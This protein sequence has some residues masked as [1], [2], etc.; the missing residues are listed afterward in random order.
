MTWHRQIQSTSRNLTQFNWKR[1]P[2]VFRLFYF[3]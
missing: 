2:A 3:I 1:W